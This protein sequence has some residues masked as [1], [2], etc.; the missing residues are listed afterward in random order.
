MVLFGFSRSFWTL[1]FR[2]SLPV[3]FECA[4]CLLTCLSQ[5]LFTWR[6]E[7]DIRCH[8]MRDGGTHGRNQHG[9][10]IFIVAICLDRWLCDWVGHLTYGAM[11]IADTD[12]W[13]F[14][15]LIGGTLSRPQDRWPHLFAHPF[16][17]EY[18]Y[19]LPCL[20]VAA[21]CCMSWVLTAAFLKEVRLFYPPNL[22]AC[23][24]KT[25][26]ADNVP[27]APTGIDRHLGCLA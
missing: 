8:E 24:R 13:S 17:A 18:P 26:Y 15:P 1:V 19:L 25:R 5:S 14:S 23:W 9:A 2:C 16:W 4:I 22:E 3:V 12:S 6:S 11:S 7:R 10:R 20:V 21:Y 27:Y